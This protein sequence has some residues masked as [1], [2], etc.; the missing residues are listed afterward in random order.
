[1]CC[2]QIEHKKIAQSKKP[3][4]TVDAFSHIQHYSHGSTQRRELSAEFRQSAEK[5]GWNGDNNVI[6]SISNR[7]IRDIGQFI[8]EG[9]RHYARLPGERYAPLDSARRNTA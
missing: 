9:V 4:P 8:N 5:C 6:N 2:L 3:L 7:K 1:M